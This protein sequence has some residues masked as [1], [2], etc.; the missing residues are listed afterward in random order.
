MQ[1]LSDFINLN[2]QIKRKL[3][4]MKKIQ[5]MILKV[6]GFKYAT[7]LYLSMGYYHIRLST[8][9]INIC[10]IILPWCKYKYKRLPMGV[11]NSP[12][13]FQGG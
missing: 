10:T 6:E 5:Y 11:F 12:E 7:S 3:Y 2:S 1:F 9:V 13:I 8:N 4:P